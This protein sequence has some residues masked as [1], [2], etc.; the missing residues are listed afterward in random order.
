[1]NLKKWISSAAAIG[2][3]FL[4]ASSVFAEEELARMSVTY[5]SDA[6]MKAAVEETLYPVDLLETEDFEDY[7]SN[8]GYSE[9]GKVSGK[10]SAMQKLYEK[11]DEQAKLFHNNP[12]RNI[13]ADDSAYIVDMVPF[14]LEELDMYD[15]A[16]VWKVYKNDHPLYYWISS[17]V[18]FAGV[19]GASELYLC[20]LTEEPYANGV[21]RQSY[22]DKI[23]EEIDEYLELAKDCGS[24]Y[25]IALAYYDSI[26]DRIDYAYEEDGKTPQDDIWA[27]NIL[28]VFD[29][30]DGEIGYG[31]CEGYARTFQLL[32]NA[33]GVE[34]I[35]VSG[36]AGEAHAWNMVQ[37]DGKW[38]WCDPTWD[39]TREQ[40][41]GIQHTYFCL[42]DQKFVN[43][44]PDTPEG[45][46][47]SYLYELPERA[48]EPYKPQK[49]DG[50]LLGTRFTE[51]MFSYTVVGYHTVQVTAVDCKGGTLKLPG[52]VVHD[53]KMCTVVAI[54]AIDGDG[55]VTAIEWPEDHPEKII[56]PASLRYIEPYTF[57][58][59]TESRGIK[60]I[61]IEEGNRYFRSVD[62]VLFSA[63][64][65]TLLD[66]PDG[67]EAA[68]YRVPA[69]VKTL[70]EFSFMNNRN[71]KK[72][73]LPDTLTSI[74]VEAF[75][76]CTELTDVD[77]YNVSDGTVIE[78]EYA[79]DL[80]DG[81]QELG[82]AAFAACLKIPSVRVPAQITELHGQTFF[83]CT[84]LEK[85]ELSENLRKLGN[86][87]FYYCLM[88][89]DVYF[90]G[91][92]PEVWGSE[93]F[94]RTSNELT[95]HYN[96]EMTDNNWYE[97]D[98][99]Q[100]P[101]RD[102]YY[103][104]KASIIISDPD[105]PGDPDD[106]NEPGE[107][108]N[109][110]DPNVPEDDDP[111]DPDLPGDFD[112]PEESVILGD[113]DGDGR[114]TTSDA[115]AILRYIVGYV[116]TGINIQYGDV[117]SDEEITT[118]DASAILRYIVG[119]TDNPNIGQPIEY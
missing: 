49:T 85:V 52:T 28:S 89:K 8:Y 17:A 54:G 1:M 24:H 109:P 23:E 81:L 119:Y 58:S 42:T 84:S 5:L 88:L 44:N 33:A 111:T 13:E 45:I 21:D 108:D 105:E 61:E 100:V 90:M 50:L 110:D 78:S 20:L 65:A 30:E 63:D 35:F 32:L 40:G 77:V 66:Y 80:P 11:L 98:E 57:Y 86:Q 71:L 96:P 38:Y 83:D 15:A 46:G 92:V 3:A 31:V 103:R 6:E 70:G 26:I 115:S 53:G 2:C 34:N 112:E 101:G 91:E 14:S 75:Y 47:L 99:W 76:E 7:A 37:L 94:G 118:S 22:N 51:G 102:E 9:L 56:I 95:L 27:H 106:P 79:V 104:T 87:E 107:P 117:D 62:G 60:S 72:V 113:V 67:R 116:D 25:Q 16:A 74:E 4:M 114:I 55:K 12:T 82:T 18:S 59:G 10:G 39:D 97:S 43:H 41:W 93:N 69:E 68:D 64:M 29:H 36:W 73:E 48:A 19:Q